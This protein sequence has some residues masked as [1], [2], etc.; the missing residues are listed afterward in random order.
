[1]KDRPTLAL[2]KRIVLLAW[3]AEL[4]LRRALSRGWRRR[5]WDLL[6]ECRACGCCCVEP[7]I[8]AD[9][10][11]WHLPIVRWLLY[12]WQCQVNGMGLQGQEDRSHDLIFLCTHYDPVSK[13]CDSYTTRPGMCR[14][15]PRV[16]LGQPWPE[17]FETCGY[18]VR[19]RKS[20]RLRAGIEATSLS[21]EAKAELRRKLRLD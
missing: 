16:L 2:L 1:V 18:R 20:E 12:R 6:G 17:L 8:H 4:W 19:A 11:T 7:S 14:D 9:P 3:S 15:Y 21:P 13:R 5:Y 10:L